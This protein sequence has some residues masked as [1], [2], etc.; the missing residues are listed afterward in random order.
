[1]RLM[2]RTRTTINTFT[3][4]ANHC[5]AESRSHPSILHCLS[6]S[7]RDH[8]QKAEEASL[9]LVARYEQ[10]GI[11]RTHLDGLPVTASAT[12][13]DQLGHTIA[14]LFQELEGMAEA[15]TDFT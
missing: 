2:I 10:I 6:V 1:M 14:G 7:A 15:E 13:R 4:G 9:G 11:C 3:A 12:Q 8:R 5:P